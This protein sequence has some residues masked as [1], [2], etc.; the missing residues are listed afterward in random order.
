MLKNRDSAVW[1]PI[2]AC[3][4]N[5]L[6]KV[7]FGLLFCSIIRLISLNH[8]FSLRMESTLHQQISAMKQSLL[9]EVFLFLFDGNVVR[10]F[11]FYI[12]VNLALY[13]RPIFFP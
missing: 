13:F 11:Q 9:D 6:Y 2:N 5:W 7:S 3:L 10:F 4:H 1:E 12:Y 8:L